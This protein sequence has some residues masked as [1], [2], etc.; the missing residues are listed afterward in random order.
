M[1]HFTKLKLGGVFM[2]N[3]E[4]HGVSEVNSGLL[5]GLIAGLVLSSPFADDAVITSCNDV[6]I[7]IHGNDRPYLRVACTDDSEAQLVIETL[8]PLKVDIEWLK[9]GGFIPAQDRA[10]Y[11]SD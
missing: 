4:I 2:P 9:L 6:V 10:L 5:A 11:R 7:G 3:I 1:L 8:K